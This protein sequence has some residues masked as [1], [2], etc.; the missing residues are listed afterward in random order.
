[1][2]PSN[3]GTGEDREDREDQASTVPDVFFA[4]RLLEA[5]GGSGLRFTS[6]HAA[7]RPF[8]TASEP[9][10]EDILDAYLEQPDDCKLFVAVSDERGNWATCFLVAKP[11]AND[12][13]IMRDDRSFVSA[14]VS[15]DLRFDWAAFFID[16]YI[17]R[18]FV[19]ARTV[20]AHS[21][22]VA[23]DLVACLAVSKTKQAAKAHIAASTGA[24]GS[25]PYSTSKILAFYASSSAGRA[26]P[27]A[28]E[29][30]SRTGAP[31]YARDA[32]VPWD[33][34]LLPEISAV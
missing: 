7:L 23:A 9:T 22:L 32:V 5:S 11:P 2:P 26:K 19:T 10:F 1:M 34:H 13:K 24:T 33:A 18:L 29:D 27:R 17:A 21:R 31:A 28:T 4:S 3:V 20:Q 25:A 6:T 16:C 14:V 8:I 15:R 12:L 30:R